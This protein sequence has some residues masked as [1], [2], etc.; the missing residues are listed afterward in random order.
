MPHCV[1]NVTTA[2]SIWVTAALGVLC[3]LAVAVAGVLFLLLAGG[4]IEKWCL[5]ALGIEE[6]ADPPDSR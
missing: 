5:E 4:T 2:A 1:D 3:G 6:K